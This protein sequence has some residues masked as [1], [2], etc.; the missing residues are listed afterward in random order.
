MPLAR[1]VQLREQEGARHAGMSRTTLA[2]AYEVVSYMQQHGNKISSAKLAELYATKGGLNE[3]SEEVSVKFVDASLYVNKR[4]L[5]VP[6]VRKALLAIEARHGIKTPFQSIYTMRALCEKAERQE[7]IEW[8]ID[9]L[10]H[11]VMIGQL[12]LTDINIRNI[13]GKSPGANGRGL[14]DITN[15]KRAFAL[16][17][18]STYSVKFDIETR[19]IISTMTASHGEYYRL[20]GHPEDKKAKNISFMAEL[21]ESGQMLVRFVE[22]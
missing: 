6:G 21:K 16:L 17:I 15:L 10:M 22:A 2:R 9:S 18:A 7:F 8:A 11:E 5:S 4:A 1:S 14:I 19:N 3:L 13:L 12:L 20:F